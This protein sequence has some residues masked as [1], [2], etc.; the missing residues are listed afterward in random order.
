MDTVCNYTIMSHNH[1]QWA[2]VPAYLLPDLRWPKLGERSGEVSST[3]AIF[4][5][6]PN[7]TVYILF[8]EKEDQLFWESIVPA[9]M[10]TSG[11]IANASLQIK[12]WIAI[13]CTAILEFK[14]YGLAVSRDRNEEGTSRTND[15]DV[16][17]A[18]NHR[19]SCRSRVRW[20]QMGGGKMANSTAR[21]ASMTSWPSRIWTRGRRLFVVK[22]VGCE[23]NANANG[24]CCW[25]LGPLDIEE[26]DCVQQRKESDSTEGDGWIDRKRTASVLA[27]VFWQSNWEGSIY[28]SPHHRFAEEVLEEVLVCSVEVT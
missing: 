26:I 9:R 25:C 21:V 13:T 4:L 7:Y 8:E 12:T 6:T 14:D 11:D 28:Q 20:S 2:P 15:F 16:M 10:G 1:N 23:W 5:Y 17:C 18:W 27:S 22:A 3:S 24:S 19:R